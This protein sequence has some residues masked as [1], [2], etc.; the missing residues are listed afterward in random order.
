MDA[1]GKDDIVTMDD[2]G[3][4]NILYGTVR[5]VAGKEEHVFTKKL[6]ESGFGMRLSKEVRHDG[7]AFSFQGLKFP[8]QGSEPTGKSS[9]LSGLTGAVNQ[10]MLDNLLYYKYAYDGGND[11]SST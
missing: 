10:G 8:D 2:S 6:I 1:D 4:I 5:N 3:E 11:N 7:G 9:N